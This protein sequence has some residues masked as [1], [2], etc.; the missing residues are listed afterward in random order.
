MARNCVLKCLKELRSPIVLPHNQTCLIGR[1]KET[2]I[3]SKR[4]SKHQVEVLA[5]YTT[6]TVTVRQI[7][8][9]VTGVNGKA[10]LFGSTT[11]LKHKDILEVLLGEYHYQVEFDPPP[12]ITPEKKN[13]TTDLET[14]LGE[15]GIEMYLRKKKNTAE[16]NGSK[17]KKARTGTENEDE[18]WVEY[19]N[20]SLL[21]FNKNM[22]GRAKIAGYDMDGT[23]ITT[24]SGKVFAVNY[25]DWK[26][27]YS[28]V[29]GK[30]KQLHEDGYKLVIFT[31][32]AGIAAGK[33]TVAG[34]QKK[35]SNI[36]SKFGV[37]FQVF[38]STGKGNYRKP[39]LGMWNFLKNEA[40]GGVDIDMKESMFIGD[41]AGRPAEGKKKKDFSFS[42][43][44][45]ALN[46]G[47]QFFT[48]EEHFLGVKT[49][50]YNMPEFDP[51]AV[52]ESV[53][54]FDPP[55]TKVPKHNLEVIIFVGYPGSGKSFLS[56]KHF[57]PLGYVQANRDSLGSWQKCLSVMETSLQDGNNV[58][59]DNTNPDVESRKRYIDVA[60]K[61]NVPV[62]CFVF[63]VS[64]DHCRHNNKFRE[65]SGAN[66]SKVSDMIYNMYKSKFEEP[67]LKEGFDD[68]VKVNFVP[69]FRASKEKELYRMFLLEK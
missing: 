32:Q 59:I 13:C 1:S 65:L 26:I 12:D 54:L 51:R 64:K 4:C 39:A 38:V 43:R 56:T 25:D 58:V 14:P 15:V 63:N 34:V 5:N 2:R 69:N 31:N 60:K 57:A 67:T 49:Q 3:K 36:I 23:L 50:K 30:L 42:D 45:F 18:G 7:G 46:M 8:P 11:N 28:E 9:N 68:I 29:P 55:S 41:A 37:P 21:V 66:H 10:L 17:A 62:R 24:Q 40:N 33:H 16:E 27:I 35:I 22:E 61:M 48:P 20:E 52:D 19:D 47:I 6:Y 53:S 44:L